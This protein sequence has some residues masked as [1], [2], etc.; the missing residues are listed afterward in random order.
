M[1]P[2]CSRLPAGP[3]LTVTNNGRGNRQGRRALCILGITFHANLNIS[4][5]FGET[6]IRQIVTWS[7]KTHGFFRNTQHHDRLVN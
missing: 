2:K 6:T 3:V 1:A 5:A 4:E 7:L